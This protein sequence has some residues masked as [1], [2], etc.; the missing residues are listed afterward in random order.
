MTS[1]VSLTQ[2]NNSLKTVLDN[3][4]KAE[5]PQRH[6]PPS[7]SSSS[8]GIRER[9]NG[10]VLSKLVDANS[11]LATLETMAELVDDLIQSQTR[12]KLQTFLSGDCGP[13]DAAISAASVHFHEKLLPVIA[14][15][16]SNNHYDDLE[17]MSFL[18]W[19][20]QN[21]LMT[22]LSKLL[23]TAPIDAL[24]FRSA[25]LNAICTFRPP[26]SGSTEIVRSSEFLGLVSSHRHYLQGPLGTRLLFLSIEVDCLELTRLLVS[27]GVDINRI[28]L[29]S[30]THTAPVAFAARTG[31]EHTINYLIST[32]AD[33]N[34]R[35]SI[36]G[37]NCNH[38][39]ALFEA[40]EF[41]HFHIVKLLLEKGAHF[42]G[43]ET[44]DDRNIFQLA[45]N[46]NQAIYSILR[47]RIPLID[48]PD[49][50][51]LI[52]A[53]EMGN[54]E[55]SSLLLKHGIVHTEI[56]ERALHGA[57]KAGKV[58]AVGTLLRRGVDP[59]ARLAHPLWDSTTESY[60]NASDFISPIRLLL[61]E[62]ENADQVP[63]LLYLL[64][65]A[66]AEVDEETAQELRD[67][68]VDC[69]AE[70]PSTALHILSVLLQSDG[71]AAWVRP[72]L[73]VCWAG[74]GHIFSCGELLDTGTA[75]N[76]Y[77]LLGE[78]ALQVA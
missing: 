11:K 15:M 31:N 8:Y 69:F 38:R 18:N 65:K 25:L 2:G 4:S 58:N 44:A 7:P 23:E 22:Q 54:H 40:V 60:C 53:A 37:C 57:I 32:G 3:Y 21:G 59:N 71:N 29:R 24:A 10:W 51:E 41:D 49:V 20:I 35:C 45:W 55:V 26:L 78:S 56:M 77:G 1:L 13:C 48:K 61:H 5:R 68:R 66:G 43:D 19:V 75:I 9:Q 28:V 39:T 12:T 16:I 52:D 62:Y 64:I 34:K 36:E 42:N 76:G 27:H 6:V 74:T 63:D 72:A 33:I 50:F 67:G 73:L 47:E 46:R 30:Y 70:D 14:F 17:I